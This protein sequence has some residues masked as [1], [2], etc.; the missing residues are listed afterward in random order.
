[1][2]LLEELETELKYLQER[3]VKSGL[4]PLD[5]SL[6]T[7]PAFSPDPVPAPDPVAAGEKAG[8]QGLR[9]RDYPYVYGAGAGGV[10]SLAGKGMGIAGREIQKLS[11]VESP[12]AYAADKI[13][14]AM[15][16]V[17]PVTSALGRKGV[18]IARDVQAS[19]QTEDRKAADAVSQQPKYKLIH[20]LGE[21]L[22]DAEKPT[23]ALGKRTSQFYEDLLSNDARKLKNSPWYKAEGLGAKFL[24]ASL[25]A[26]ESL[27]QMAVTAVAGAPI[28]ASLKVT[29]ATKALGAGVARLG[30]SKKM[31]P[32]VA[33]WLSDGLAYSTPEGVLAGLANAEEVGNE[34]VGMAHEELLKSPKYM[35][36][37]E[38][39]SADK[40]PDERSGKAKQLLIE[41]AE[42]FALGATFIASTVT[43]M[44]AGGGIF[45][46]AGASTSFIKRRVLGFAKEGVQEFFQS[47]PGEKLPANLA[48]QLFADPEQPLMQ[49]VWS[50]A[51]AGAGPGALVG[52]FVG[53]GKP[54]VNPGQALDDAKIER[55]KLKDQSIRTLRANKASDEDLISIMQSP[56]ALAEYG[57]VPS[58]VKGLITNKARAAQELTEFKATLDAAPS[59]AIRQGIM[60]SFQGQATQKLDQQ[61][62]PG[63]PDDR[64]EAEP[65]TEQTPEAKEAKREE[66]GKVAP[67]E[68]R[69]SEAVGTKLIKGF[70]KVQSFQKTG[71]LEQAGQL[72][73]N[74]MYAFNHQVQQ[75]SNV[76]EAERT[77]ADKEFEQ[78]MLKVL[79]DQGVIEQDKQAPLEL[80]ERRANVKR[81][82][83]IEE[84]SPKEMKRELL[85]NDLTGIPNK[86]ALKENVQKAEEE[87]KPKTVIFVDADSLKTVNDLGGH[88]AGD[89]LLKGIANAVKEV[90]PDLGFHISGDEFVLLADNP[91]QAKEKAK[92]LEKI[93][94]SQEIVFTLENGDEYTYSGLGASYGIAD[95]IEEADAKMGLHKTEREEAGARV[96]RG[97]TPPGLRKTASREGEVSESPEQAGLL[98]KG[99]EVT[100][101]A[102]S[103]ELSAEFKKVLVLQNTGKSEQA[104]QLQDQIIEKIND[105]VQQ[106]DEIPEADRTKADKE[107]EQKM[108]EVLTGPMVVKSE[109]KAAVVKS[110]KEEEGP[111]N[112]E[113][114][115]AQLT[116]Q[117]ELLAKAKKQ[118]KSQKVVKA[119]IQSLEN[120][121][122]E[123]QKGVLAARV[124]IRS[125]LQST[126][127]QVAGN[128]LSSLGLKKVPSII[129]IVQTFAELPQEVKEGLK[130]HGD[131][132]AAM[133][134]P[135][136]TSRLKT[137][138]IAKS[139]ERATVD[140]WLKTIE[141]WVTDK[142]ITRT[143]GKRKGE[144]YIK[145]GSMPKPVRDEVHFSG[146]IPWLESLDQVYV[147]KDEIN[148]FLDEQGLRFTEEILGDIRYKESNL[149]SEEAAE[150]STK[151]KYQ[152]SLVAIRK[153]IVSTF[154][155]SSAIADHTIQAVNN[156]Y[157]SMPRNSLSH[158]MLHADIE[159]SIKNHTST[160]ITFASTRELWLLVDEYYG[161]RDAVEEM[162]GFPEGSWEPGEG[163]STRITDWPDMVLKGD[164]K[165]YREQLLTLPY[166]KDDL[167]TTIFSGGHYD[168][169]TL[170][171]TRSDIREGKIKGKNQGVFFINE[172][173]S[174]WHKE[175]IKYGYKGPQD[176][177]ELIK[178][179]KIAE[180]V[181]Q[182]FRDKA[183]DNNYSF[184]QQKLYQALL[185][186]FDR[187]PQ[188]ES[189]DGIIEGVRSIASLEVD[190]NQSEYTAFV[191][192]ETPSFQILID[193]SM[194]IKRRAKAPPD[195][196]FKKN[197]ELVTLKRMLMQAVMEDT[198]AVAFPSTP[199]QV[200][201]IEQWGVV[202]T[203]TQRGNIVHMPD[204]RWLVTFGKGFASELIRDADTQDTQDEFPSYQTVTPV[205][206][207]Y[208]TWLP[209]IANKFLEPYGIKVEPVE[210]Q[211]HTVQ[212]FRI[213]PELREAT[214]NGLP[215]ASYTDQA[216]AGVYHK[217]KIYLIA[218]NI[219]PNQDLAPLL[220][221]EGGHW[222]RANDSAFQDKYQQM[223]DQIRNIA[224]GSRTLAEAEA[225]Q[226]A[227]AKAMSEGE[228]LN[229][230]QVE[231][232]TL[233]YFLQ[234]QANVNLPWYKKIISLV[235]QFLFKHFGV[236]ASKLNMSGYD[237]AQV[238]VKELERTLKAKVL[239]ATGMPMASRAG[240]PEMSPE[241]R[242]IMERVFRTPEAPSKKAQIKE[243]QKARQRILDRAKKSRNP[244]VKKLAINAFKRTK[245][246][247]TIGT[248]E[249]LFGLPEYTFAKDKAAQK[250]MQI[251]LRA[252]EDKFRAQEDILTKDFT[253]LSEK[254]QKNKKEY[255]KVGGYLREADKT[256]IGFRVHQDKEGWSIIGLADK[257]L[258]EGIPDET[259]AVAARWKHEEKSLRHSLT[260][261]SP[262]AIQFI[263]EFRALTDR[264][265][266]EQIR[267][268]QQQIDSAEKYG[269]PV[270]RVAGEGT[271][272]LA[273]AIATIGDLRGTYFPR[274]R[275][276]RTYVLRASKKEEE[277]I[278]LT[279][280]WAMP[281]DTESWDITNKVKEVLRAKLPVGRK[282]IEL[283]NKGY[284]VE[285]PTLSPVL[286]D[287][288]YDAPGLAASMDA[289]L[290][291][292]EDS[293]PGADSEALQKLNQLLVKQMAELYKAKGSLSSRLSRVENYVTGFE[294]DPIKAATSHA[295]KVASSV[296]KRR[297]IRGMVLAFTGRDVSFS[298]Y[299]EDNPDAEYKEY[300]AYV[301]GKRV[302]PTEQAELYKTVKEYIQYIATPSNANDRALGYL[303]AASM[304]A[305]LGFRV[306]SAAVN[307]TN[308]VMAVP[309]TIAGH[310]GLSINES[311]KIII[312]ASAIYGVHRTMHSRAKGVSEEDIKSVTAQVVNMAKAVGEKTAEAIAKPVNYSKAELDIFAKISFNGWDQAHFNI[313]ALR[314]LQ[315]YA[316]QTFNNVM[317]ASM[318]M[319]GAAEK[320]NRAITIFAAYK[321]LEIK[322]EK[323]GINKTQDEMLG[324]A[325][326]ISNRAHGIYGKA[327]K[328][329]AV[330][331]YKILDLF[332]TFLKFQHNYMLNMLEIGVKK[333]NLPAA[334][335][336]LLFP[337]VMSGAGATLATP[338]L[339]ALMKLFGFSDDPEED[340]HHWAEEHLP[341]IMQ[342][343]A[344]H[345]AFG[346]FNL[347]F[348]GSL[349]MTNPF[350]T[351]LKEVVG[352][353]GAVIFDMWEMAKHFR[354][355]EWSKGIEAGVPTFLEAPLKGRRF[356]VEGVTTKTYSP[357]FHG[358]ERLKATAMERLLMSFSFNTARL[359]GIREKQW[360]ETKVKQSFSKDRQGILRRLKKIKL[361]SD[362]K[363]IEALARI[364]EGVD[365]FNLRVD[366]APPRYQIQYLTW[367]QLNRSLKQ[368]MKPSKYERER[369]QVD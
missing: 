30:L 117:G 25:Q 333:K 169:N 137:N 174:D 326:H 168:P 297:T 62:Q 331:K 86:R 52:G 78:K 313:E 182:S 178:E 219:D 139:N 7:A 151:Q 31:A 208:T 200:A 33:D 134:G 38:S 284:L 133:A 130:K 70:E 87:G 349:Q 357:V 124:E 148:T 179:Q 120:Q 223:L 157:K 251:A 368:A 146:L 187:I 165:Y 183:I 10:V 355:R 213:T 16:T 198:G 300:M 369:G 143:K 216:P 221:H 202:A 98:E 66:P 160:E 351:K 336:L 274:E 149:S 24:A 79:A 40:N 110:D 259:A 118:K 207:R 322:Y 299:Q 129:E 194:R 354:Y 253:K 311:F 100:S 314:P 20:T 59:D 36:Y 359:S 330:Q 228:R 42:V 13:Y 343:M 51:L 95:T 19:V 337:A 225:M 303:K 246:T 155:V 325:H 109:K 240:K 264:A 281:E 235:K 332:Y 244:A 119:E 248:I 132:L 39:T 318:Y 267:D 27:P 309:A 29:G 54:G 307:S 204:G 8:S 366:N 41:D 270:P 35:E 105:R 57:L 211:D 218:D 316:S 266:N 294:T 345:G 344:R 356:R 258:E 308:M 367:K 189:V 74:L 358:K 250:V 209:R 53:S 320:A 162:Y 247:P 83:L 210:F 196:P 255:E 127:D 166:D 260:K 28:S 111:K 224:N 206:E 352:A 49:D 184:F 249:W 199:E 186:R 296:V 230:F 34:I 252:D 279:F 197:W 346:L 254:L 335:H 67:V 365:E 18:E 310:T 69:T 263:E 315:G 171:H 304:F 55:N 273:K 220:I 268:L 152:D 271:P 126:A 164:A 173:Q 212:G 121:L 277:D 278:L 106:I 163:V 347:N 289:L 114:L 321:A 301:A 327:V 131:T 113:Q 104:N 92:K 172:M 239:Q 291:R 363:N 108:F 12:L 85:V 232:E 2:S 93:L 222:L 63:V 350:P 295:Q 153:H 135:R 227:M 22:E 89:A 4:P 328:P 192:E 138:F 45:G 269:L 215:L 217:G 193:S 302:D 361:S 15:K 44:L 340:L 140:E 3:K 23:M 145:E 82:K 150:V 243:V 288:V 136:W 241:Q 317:T 265:F 141:R 122:Q 339:A 47:G 257:I 75:I 175:G 73:D 342:R 68:V 147:T 37:F 32:K 324:E 360:R 48:L 185:S 56:A 214:E 6:S 262:E 231:E 81:R 125:T 84:M 116:Q 46:K 305:Y 188:S 77:K 245:T 287:T 72:Q 61:I 142:E 144:T 80:T 64:K 286:A 112:V 195:A 285:G 101:E 65:E 11:K 91:K 236:S 90:D 156:T 191:E 226:I 237:F 158:K 96:G 298:E 14:G 280:E 26:T 348:K 203:D 128:L 170:I 261:Y 161:L 319:F 5:S 159:K 312:Q 99:E 276:N 229:V 154:N 177:A 341:N 233:M 201:E 167:A 234:D 329:F 272:T 1:M 364:Q 180:E 88:A 205:I 43:G 282:I 190:F 181:K 353:P 71:E 21:S 238:I 334:L 275:P 362:P 176:R 94:D 283:Q 102:V 76:P 290:S 58:D 97:K 323:E 256:G 123:A 292:A 242:E 107:F 338:A 306:S 60:N 17:A 50:A 9:K 293:T 115:K 103:T